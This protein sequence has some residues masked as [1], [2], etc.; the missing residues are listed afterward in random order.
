[1]SSLERGL[2][3]VGVTDLSIEIGKHIKVK[4]AHD[5]EKGM[6]TLSA[7]P[8]DHRAKANAVATIRRELNRIGITDP[9]FEMRLV[10]S[11]QQML[12]EAQ[13]WELLDKWESEVAESPEG[14]D[15]SR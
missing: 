1:M 11:A 10:L 12:D 14:G 8:S 7:T 13:V 3:L 9:R 2:K 5:G 6:V 4:F 15:N